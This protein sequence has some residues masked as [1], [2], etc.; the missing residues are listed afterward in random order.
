MNEMRKC[1]NH[2]THDPL[3]SVACFKNIRTKRTEM[4]NRYVQ[5]TTTILIEFSRALAAL[6][7]IDFYLIWPF[8]RCSIPFHNMVSSARP[9]ALCGI[10][11]T[12]TEWFAKTTPTPHGNECTQL[13]ALC[14]AHI[15]STSTEFSDANAWEIE[16]KRPSISNSIDGIHTVRIQ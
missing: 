6:P 8:L 12:N 5:L 13:S 15:A 2:M 14:V 3:L 1:I 4:K 7:Q 11:K 10:L 16:K 9:T